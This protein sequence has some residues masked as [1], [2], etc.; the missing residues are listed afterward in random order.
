MNQ[1]QQNYKIAK[2]IHSKALDYVS[3]EFER[4]IDEAGIDFDEG[5]IDAIVEIDMAV[6]E[7]YNI[8]VLADE[9]RKAQ[10]A[11]M[12]WGIEVLKDVEKYDEIKPLLKDSLINIY[13]DRL[14]EI[15]A[16]ME[17]KLI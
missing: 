17:V 16:K 6:N 10:D 15:F 14:C 7:R 8:N 11:L 12:A 5:D 9:L 4:R 13:K 1:L 3:E 2:A